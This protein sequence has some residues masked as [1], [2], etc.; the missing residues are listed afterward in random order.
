MTSGTESVVTV[1]SKPL[2]GR[3]LLTPS[4]WNDFV[5]WDD[6]IN[7]SENLAYRGL[8]AAQFKY[9]FTTMLL[10]HYIPLT[11]MTFGMDYVLWGMN[12]M[13]YHLTSLIVHAA[14]AAVFYL[15]ALR[16]LQKATTL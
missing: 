9:F 5:D 11:W 14:G 7:L 2:A 8:G 15:V 4:L 1:A 10:G 12:P 13:G 3:R 16:I 6:Q